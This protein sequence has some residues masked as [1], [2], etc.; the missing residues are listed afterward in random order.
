M[1][2]FYVI[3]N[4]LT[5][6]NT[7]FIKKLLKLTLLNNRIIFLR[8]C[9]C[10]CVCACGCVWK[11]LNIDNIDTKQGKNVFEIIRNSLSIS[12]SSSCGKNMKTHFSVC[13]QTYVNS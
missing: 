5:L 1:I 11:Y 9:V 2:L 10:V 12:G 6:Y 3:E 7:S 4:Y 8:V 13:R